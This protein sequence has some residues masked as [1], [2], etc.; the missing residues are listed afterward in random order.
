M[1][2]DWLT[3]LNEVSIEHFSKCAQDEEDEII[4]EERKLIGI[5]LLDFES[6][7]CLDWVMVK[8]L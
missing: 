8:D 5:L 4:P 2:Y 3:L 7:N 6:M 1:T